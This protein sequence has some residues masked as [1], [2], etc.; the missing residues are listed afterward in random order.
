MLCYG[1]GNC[2]C[3]NCQDKYNDQLARSRTTLLVGEQYRMSIDGRDGFRVLL[4]SPDELDGRGA[5]RAHVIVLEDNPYV[6]VGAECRS[7]ANTL[8][9]LPR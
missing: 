3:L 5:R 2:D 9:A 7:L 6:K 1:F 4:I 8:E